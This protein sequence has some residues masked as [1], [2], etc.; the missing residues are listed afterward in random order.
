M[1]PD[2]PTDPLHATFNLLFVCTGNTCRSPMA[3]ALARR[4]LERRGWRH[5]RVASAGSSATHGLPASEHAAAVAAEA[6]LPLDAHAS[7]PLT[8]ELVEWAD[9]ILAMSP[10]HLGPVA[11]LGGE[12]KMALLGAFAAGEDGGSRP[13]A[14]PYGGDRDLY[15]ETFR[16]LETLVRDSLERLAPFLHP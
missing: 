14:D 4:E 2:A 5:V 3:E 7:Q 16:D 13:V 15:Q 1:S 9:L 8:E 12:E 11:R 6:G 10:S